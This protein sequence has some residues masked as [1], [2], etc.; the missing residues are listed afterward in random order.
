M[1]TYIVFHKYYVY[2]YFENN[3]SNLTGD[4][5]VSDSLNK[6]TIKGFKSIKELKSFDLYN[7]NVFIGGNGAGKSNFIEFFRMIAAM[8]EPDGLKMFIEGN[9]DTYLFGGPK[10]TPYISV[11]MEF[12]Q[13]GYEFELTSNQDGFF[14]I[15]NEKRHCFSYSSPSTLSL[16]SGNF[17]P[18]LLNDRNSKGSQGQEH[19]ASW[20]TYNSIKSWTI[21]HFHDTNNNAEMRRYHDIGHNEKLF[22]DGSN[23]APYLLEL[24][25]NYPDN[26]K[27]IVNTVRLVIPFFDDFILKP[28]KNENIRLDWRQKGLKNY[29]MRPT[30]LS[31]GSIRFICLA[32]AL[33]QPD[34]P[35]TII[36]DEPELG[37]HPAAIS[38]L[39]EL[40]LD[41]SKLTQVIL[42]T[43]SPAL[44][45]HFDIEDLIV[46]NREHKASTFTRLDKKDFTAWL[47]N[48]SIGELWSKNVIDG[49]P[50]YE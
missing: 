43:Q 25:T 38:I 22:K 10:T 4:N 36:I 8:M 33:L 19:N 18:E 5:T 13:N 35:S 2:V 39:A 1:I 11:K 50:V 6:L 49:G 26:Y 44:I 16:G 3:I 14:L 41:T 29:P 30:Q 7:L 20:Y 9:A 45:N 24:R 28:D 40:V 37:L 27:E 15:N 32:T 23:I 21:Y 42:A 46:V 48:Y 17:N 31:D 12:G 34:P 47:E